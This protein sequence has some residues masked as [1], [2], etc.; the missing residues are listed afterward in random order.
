ATKVRQRRAI[1]RA[2]A[3]GRRL[4]RCIV[5]MAICD[6]LEAI[7]G[8]HRELIAQQLELALRESLQAPRLRLTDLVGQRPAIDESREPWTPIKYGPTGPD[9]WFGVVPATARFERSP[10][11]AAESLPLIIKVNPAEA[12]ARTLIPWI[13]EQKQILLGKPFWDYQCAAELDHTGP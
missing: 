3:V 6:R 12:L 1:V 4:V 5:A 11:A 8:M 2:A 7:Q 9:N 10:S 13:I